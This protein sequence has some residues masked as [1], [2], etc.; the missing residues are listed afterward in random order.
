[1]QIREGFFM[2]KIICISLIL[3]LL[4]CGC[5]TVH[6][7]EENTTE[8]PT[9]QATKK[10]PI[11][12]VAV[13]PEEAVVPFVGGIAASTPSYGDPIV[14]GLMTPDGEIVVEPV[15]EDWCLFQNGDEAFYCMKNTD[16]LTNSETPDCLDSTL[17][18]LDGTKLLTLEHEI[19]YLDSDRIVATI[20]SKQKAFIYDRGGNLIFETPEDK[21]TDGIFTE[22]LMSV[23][24]HDDGWYVVDKNG[25]TVFDGIYACEEFINGKSIARNKND[26]I[27]EYGIISAEGKWLIEPKYDLIMYFNGYYVAEDVYDADI[28][29]KDLELLCTIR[30]T[31]LSDRWFTFGTFGNKTVYSY[32]AVS[33]EDE[34]YR[35]LFTNEMIVSSNGLKATGFYDDI[36][37]FCT[38]DSE[39]KVI[40]LFD[41]DGKIALEVKAEYIEKEDNILN[42]STTE[43]SLIHTAYYNALTLEK[44]IELSYDMD[45]KM[46]PVHGLVAGCDYVAVGNLDFYMETMYEGTYGLYNYKTGEYAFEGCENCFV[47]EHFGTI[48]ITVAYKD[49]IQIY[50][51][52]LELIKEIRNALEGEF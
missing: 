15:Y 49:K 45:E 42:F 10:E 51:N 29:S 28:Y 30:Q 17:Y 23:W 25:N 19:V 24:S 39:N 44:I 2:K 52:D 21:N 8:S 5:N 13:L 31:K 9:M 6:K 27:I 46:R 7:G 38:I 50:N 41:I 40:Y 34:C 12:A 33:E 1:M 18:S 4:L 47:E 20:F 11:T 36:D 43:G 26:S 14:Y 35:D 3:V 22:G 48:Y 37:L 16:S 32:P